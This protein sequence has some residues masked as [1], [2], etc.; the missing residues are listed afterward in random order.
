MSFSTVSQEAM[1]A[2]TGMT[3]MAFL[4][5]FPPDVVLGAFTGSI[6]FLLGVTHKPKWQWLL[7]FTLAF[8]AGLQGATLVAAIGS[9]ALGLIGMH[10]TF[11]HGMG[12]M[13]AAATVVNTLG[14]LRDR[15]S[16][17]LK[18]A[19]RSGGNDE[20]AKENE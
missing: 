5:A 4:A 9:D 20:S 14:W 2:A 6:I 10:V 13:I 15:P 17:L 3:Y 11:P 12:A 19:T 8:T 18:Q 7:L 1:P 16:F